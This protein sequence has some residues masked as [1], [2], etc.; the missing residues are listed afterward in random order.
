MHQ[1]RGVDAALTLGNKKEVDI[2]VANE[3]ATTTSID[4]KWLE[5]R[6]DG[7]LDRLRERYSI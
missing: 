6:Y 3:D 7:C 4:A 2:I 5:Q 1:R